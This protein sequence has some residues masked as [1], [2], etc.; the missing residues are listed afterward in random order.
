MKNLKK[1]LALVV[2]C[3]M[4]FGMVASAAVVDFPD[5]AVTAKYAEAVKVLSALNVINGDDKGNFNPDANVTRAEM[6][7]ILCALLSKNATFGQTESGFADVTAAHWASGY[8]KHAKGLGYI[9]GYDAATFGPEDN[10]TYE[11]AIK[12]IVAALGYTLAADANGGYPAGYMMIAADKNITKNVVIADA[13]APAKRSDIALLAFNALEVG[14]M[15]RDTYGTSAEYKEGSKTLLFDKLGAWKHEGKITATYAE[16]PANYDIDK[17][18]VRFDNRVF[19]E[20]EL[21]SGFTAKLPCTDVT[22][23]EYLGYSNV[24]VYFAENEEGDDEIIAVTAKANKVTEYVFEDLDVLADAEDGLDT[25]TEFDLDEGRFTYWTSADHDDKKPTILDVEAGAVVYVNG[26]L[27][28]LDDV[29]A[30]IVGTIVAID[31]DGDDEIDLFKVTKYDIAI[32]DSINAKT[33]RVRFNGEA[34]NTT[35]KA[36]IALNEDACEYLKNITVTIDGAAA[37]IADLQKDDVVYV[38]ANSYDATA[39]TFIEFIAS[40]KTVEGKAMSAVVDDVVTIGSEEYDVFPGFEIEIKEE[41]KF[42]LT[43]DG[44]IVAKDVSVA[45]LDKYAYIYKI[46]ANAFGD[47]SIRMFDAEGNDVTYDVSERIEINSVY[48]SAKRSAKQGFTA[49]ELAEIFAVEYDYADDADAEAIEAAAA[50]AVAELVEALDGDDEDE[51]VCA[52][53]IIAGLAAGAAA[54]KLISYELTGSE[55]TAINFGEAVNPGEDL[56]WKGNM[57]INDARVS[58]IP[59]AGAK[60][61]MV[62]EDKDISEWKVVAADALVVD[63]EYPIMFY[64]YDEDAREY[65]VALIGE[66]TGDFDIKAAF[67]YF[68]S[69]V[70]SFYGEDEEEAWK[71]TFIQGGEEK[72]A[73][74]MAEDEAELD[75]LELGDV[76]FYQTADDVNVITDIDDLFAPAAIDPEGYDFAEADEFAGFEANGNFIYTYSEDIQDN[77]VQYGII[78]AVAAKDGALE[79]TIADAAGNIK[80]SSYTY[81]VGEDANIVVYNALKRNDKDKVY[82][83]TED[84]LLPSEIRTVAGQ[85]DFD[86]EDETHFHYVLVRLYKDTVVDVYVINY[87]N[88]EF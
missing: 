17:A 87:T 74:V 86:D 69:A 76:F 42:F 44:M 35:G 50:E 24:T 53:E 61:F 19:D 5:V 67:A 59:A 75:G 85:I 66:S 27:G 48:P 29:N 36:S 9:N 77:E 23:P 40:R 83:G 68:K 54:D 65:G 15:E 46:G 1:L 21:V 33:L 88:R 43:A 3:V 30:D 78:G 32:V 10:V 73:Y 38:R 55:I 60:F 70:S 12:L 6:A 41:G 37:E 13:T 14:M 72:I 82:V 7:K 62:D 31:T 28:D 81:T 25:D 71:V 47:K 45:K 18:E 56:V 4:V 58:T 8:V 63:R 2:A 52:E 26:V 51:A 80:G 11:Q 79:L 49:V 64:A 34:L 20:E 84:N 57:F 39:I 22:A 16:D